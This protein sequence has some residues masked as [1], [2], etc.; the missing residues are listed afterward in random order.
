MKIIYQHLRPPKNSMERKFVSCLN[1]KHKV[2]SLIDEG[3][4]ECLKKVNKEHNWVMS[5]RANELS[6]GF[7]KD[8]L[9]KDRNKM[10]TKIRQW[11][12][13]QKNDNVSTVK[14]KK[15]IKEDQRSHTIAGSCVWRFFGRFERDEGN[16]Q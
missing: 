15:G 4:R 13:Y 7:V 16:V 11:V 10:G 9:S 3:V 8:S 14:E 12:L 5:E 2:A 6:R 1:R